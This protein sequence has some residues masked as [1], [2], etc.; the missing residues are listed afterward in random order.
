MD[1]NDKYEGL[2][3]IKPDSE[4]RGDGRHL[5]P[6]GKRYKYHSQY[7][8]DPERE[9]KIVH[10]ILADT[11]QAQTRSWNNRRRL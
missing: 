2:E 6:E 10:R 9:R 1:E 4:G 7:S 3:E 5:F 8:V 11:R